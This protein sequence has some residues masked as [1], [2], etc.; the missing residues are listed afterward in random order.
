[1]NAPQKKIR[2]GWYQ[3]KPEGFF[4]QKALPATVVSAF[5][6]VG[7]KKYTKDEYFKWMRLFLSLPFHLVFFTEEEHVEFIQNCRAGLG[8]KTRIVCLP[9]EQWEANKKPSGFWEAQY[10]KDEEKHLHHPDLY[11]IWYEKM[12]F[13]QKAI[14]QNPFQHSDFVWAD[15]GILR[16]ECLVPVLQGFPVSSRIPTNRMLLLNVWP[17][18]NNDE[19]IQNGL[20]GG[21]TGKPRLGGGILAAS[22]PVWLKW[23]QLYENSLSRFIQA[24]LFVGKDQS[25]MINVA[26]ENKEFISL[27]D[28]RPIC[29]VTWFYSLLWLGATPKLFGVLQNKKKTEFYKS[30]EEIANLS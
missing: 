5:Y 26:L 10:A 2:L 7:T 25:I 30:W 22:A 8:E 11:K 13:V 23:N 28:V 3:D 17:F 20:K 4:Q 19:R 29:P 6:T 1:M 24:G 18:S 15:A 12:Y 14:E 16:Y 27:I 21:G 9:R